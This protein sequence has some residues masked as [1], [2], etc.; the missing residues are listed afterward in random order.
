MAKK[1]AVKTN[2]DFTVTTNGAA[3]ETMDTPF[4]RGFNA[5]CHID[6]DT[7]AAG[8]TATVVVQTSP[9]NSTWTTA[10]TTAAGIAKPNTVVEITL[11]NY[12][13]AQP[14][15]AGSAGTYN[16]YLTE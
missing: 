9:D 11:D 10:H 3:V 15:V 6:L 2:G 14:G 1:L 16:V 13:R 7:A 8:G 4:A 5:L 12:I